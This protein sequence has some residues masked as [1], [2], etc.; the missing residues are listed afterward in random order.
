MDPVLSQ[1]IVK[2]AFLI[3]VAVIAVAWLRY[4]GD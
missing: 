2:V 4:G 3:V 1:T